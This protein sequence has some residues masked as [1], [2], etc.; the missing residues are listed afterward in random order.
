GQRSE[1]ETRGRLDRG[2]GRRPSG[3]RWRPASPNAGS[4]GGRAGSV[5]LERAAGTLVVEAVGLLLLHERLVVLP[6][7][8][9]AALLARAGR[10]V[11]GVAE[12]GLRA[13]RRVDDG[14]GRCLRTGIDAVVDTVAVGIGRGGGE[15]GFHLV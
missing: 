8:G 9:L 11:D 10:H 12:L 3:G 5:L 7:G 2:G 13:A 1:R 6:V 14:A 15:R 4:R